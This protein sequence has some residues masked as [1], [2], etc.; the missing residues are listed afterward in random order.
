MNHAS[1]LIRGT[2]FLVLHF[3]V[4][5]IASL[6]NGQVIWDRAQIDRVRAGELASDE[7][8]ELALK[9]LRTSADVALQSGPYSVTD[10]KITPPS[11]DKHD[12]LSYSRYWWPDPEKPEGLPYIRKDRVVNRELIA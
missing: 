5:N 4:V 7:K 9:N 2:L 3:F 11:G 10:K 8:V 12:Y 1:I 6:V